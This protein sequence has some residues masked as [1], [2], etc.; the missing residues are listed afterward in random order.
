[1]LD[2]LTLQVSEA[3]KLL[4]SA[5]DRLDAAMAAIP[6]A[7]QDAVMA[8]PGLLS[9]LIGAVRARREVARLEAMIPAGQARPGDA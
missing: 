9:L 3:R 6:G 8:T 4:G 1:M 2:D 7:D 5:R